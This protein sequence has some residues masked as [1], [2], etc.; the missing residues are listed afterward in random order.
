MEIGLAL[1]T[2]EAG[3]GRPVPLAQ[4]AEQAAAAEGLG[5][6]SAW[7][8]DHL[9]IERDG[10]RHAAHDPFVTLAYLAA[11][12]SRITLGVLVAA[13]PFRHPA[14]LAREAA[15][16]ADAAPG[17]FILGLGAGWHEPEFRAFDLPF[18]RRVARLAEYLPIVKQLL[19]GR[20]LSAAGDFYR[21]REAAILTTAA[22]PPVWVAAFKPRMQHLAATFADGWNVAWLGADVSRF[23]ELKSVIDEMQSRRRRERPL[24][25]SA[26]VQVEPAADLAK[27]LAAY[28]R[29][30]A[31]HVILNFGAQPFLSFD[32]A[33]MKR[34]FS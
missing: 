27:T 34:A 8:M 13:A 33:A 5:Y 25:I 32:A 21:L 12:T 6:S 11:V 30:G 20:S 3:S 17:R 2:L 10:A 14:Q 7:V 22:A 24:T 28:E 18:E 26:G 15:A 23:R 31:E 29:A 1:G 9:L 19:A 4:V 16:V